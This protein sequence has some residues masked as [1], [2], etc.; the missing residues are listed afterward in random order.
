M[1]KRNAMNKDMKAK[2]RETHAE[3]K[4]IS[5]ALLEGPAGKF[6]SK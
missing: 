5:L 6:A 2:G 3:H 4:K 1:G